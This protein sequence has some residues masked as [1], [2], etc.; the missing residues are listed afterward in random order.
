MIK[1]DTVTRYI[2]KSF[3]TPTNFDVHNTVNY[4]YVYMYA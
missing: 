2:A 4:T 1:Y 3:S